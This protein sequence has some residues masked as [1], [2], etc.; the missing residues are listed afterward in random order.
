MGMDQRRL[1][2]MIRLL[3]VSAFTLLGT[4]LTELP[5][6]QLD[7]RPYM[8][9]HDVYAQEEHT[10]GSGVKVRSMHSLMTKPAL[11]STTVFLPLVT[12]TP[13]E[14]WH[15]GEGTYYDATGAGN[16]SFDPSPQDLMVAA[17]N[18]TDYANAALCGGFIHVEGP[19]GAVTVRIVDRCPECA[20]GDVDLSPEAFALIADLVAGRV[21]IRWR[22]ISPELQGPII[23]RFKEGS[24]QWWTAV[25][26][27]N[28]R[29]PIAKMEYRLSNGTFKD[30]P[31]TNYNYFVEASGMGPGPYT[32]RVTDMYGNV[33]QDAGIWHLEGGE[34]AGS[35]QFPPG[36]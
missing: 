2:L 29:N 21:P 20:P 18:Q 19:K 5:I 22:I 16:C 25:Q 35:G 7:W 3:F 28:H 14:I 27:R 9:R 1:C 10:N 11:A 13:E 12:R 30:I 32:F 36:P 4:I 33:L 23:Y 31:R 6:R 24:N 26:I 17:M 8:M 34:V 15:F